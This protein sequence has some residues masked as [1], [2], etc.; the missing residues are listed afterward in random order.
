MPTQVEF[1]A[2][3]PFDDGIELWPS[4]SLDPSGS[5]FDLGLF[6]DA[7][8]TFASSDLGSSPLE[9]DVIEARSDTD[10]MPID[11]PQPLGRAQ[12]GL[13]HARLGRFG[14][15]FGS[16]ASSSPA[17]PPSAPPPPIGFSLL[18]FATASPSVP[19]PTLSA[20]DEEDDGDRLT[21]PSRK[22]R[23]LEESLSRL[24]LP[25]ARKAVDL[26]LLQDQLVNLDSDQFHEYVSEVERGRPLSRA[27]QQLSRTLKRR[28][29]NRE[30]AR[31]S[32]QERKDQV[33]IM[34]ERIDALARELQE[35]KLEAAQLTAT[36]AAM[37]DEIAFSRRL[38]RSNPV[39]AQLYDEVRARHEAIRGG[40]AATAT[41][42]QSAAMEG[43]R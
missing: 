32:R 11:E 35:T 33:G 18:N 29:L 37:R 39:L 6:P 16:L 24:S 14:P 2:P 41:A 26:M 34:E 21:L 1:G 28:I 40:T 7:E 3:L 31:R 38:I 9:F 30:S 15:H 12:K 25:E 17:T 27:E 8:E 19:T 43:R 20:N 4:T 36:N 42:A 13:D 23:R 22:R 10:E 5:V